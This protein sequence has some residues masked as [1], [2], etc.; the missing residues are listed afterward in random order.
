MGFDP[1][2]LGS[3]TEMCTTCTAISGGV[4]H[5]WICFLD[6]SESFNST[7][8]GSFINIYDG[9]IQSATQADRGSS[10]PYRYKSESKR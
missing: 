9:W 4:Y 2:G 5:I 3:V 7:Y 8:N 10:G 6:S 1:M